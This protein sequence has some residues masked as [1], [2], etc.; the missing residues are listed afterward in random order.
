MSKAMRQAV[1]VLL[2]IVSLAACS[3]GAA[4]TPSDRGDPALRVAVA[5]L[6]LQRS[7]DQE[8]TADQIKQILP[9]LK[10]LRDTSP[11]D[12]PAVQAIA[13]QIVTLFTPAQRAA[14]DR[15]RA[16]GP[17]Q[18]QQRSPGNPAGPRPGVGGAGSG[19]TPDPTRRA[20]F[21]RRALDRAIRLLEANPAP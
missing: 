2:A 18:V 4:Q 21:R 12:H 19:S 8:L 5:V 6:A 17:P 7:G 3:G 15:L 14:L 16:Q 10:V 20:E 13:D 9:L 11:D 1:L